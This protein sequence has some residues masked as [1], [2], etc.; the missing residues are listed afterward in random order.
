[1]GV[2]APGG[3]VV[4]GGFG[5]V[6]DGFEAVGFEEAEVGVSDETAD[7]EDGVCVWV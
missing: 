3:H 4:E 2:D 7:L 6:D 1:M 5:V